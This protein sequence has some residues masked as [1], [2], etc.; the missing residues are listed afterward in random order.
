[1]ENDFIGAL[2]I[3]QKLKDI[4]VEQVVKLGT[5]LY[6]K[7]RKVN[8]DKLFDRIIE[9][10]E[11]IKNIQKVKNLEKQ[12]KWTYNDLLKSTGNYLSKFAYWKKK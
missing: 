7:Y 10:E 4:D 3:I 11:K 2:P 5:K 8:I 12:K 9:E 1:M 6:E